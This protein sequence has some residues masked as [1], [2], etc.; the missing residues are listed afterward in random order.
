MSGDAVRLSLPPSAS[1]TPRS[2]LESLSREDLIY[3]IKKQVDN[4]KLSRLENSKLSE[5]ILSLRN[6]LKDSEASDKNVNLTEGHNFERTDLE[7]EN[8]QLKKDVDSLKDLIA[9]LEKKLE[10]NKTT[11]NTATAVQEQKDEEDVSEAR[12]ELM[13]VKNQNKELQWTVDELR[14]LLDD[15]NQELTAFKEKR[16]VENVFSLEIADYEKTVEK[17]QK[18]LKFS[19]EECKSLTN[20]LTKSRDEFAAVS[21]EKVRLNTSLNKMKAAILKMKT[22]FDEKKTANE[23]AEKEI[24]LLK[25]KISSLNE[26]RDAE[27]LSFSEAISNSQQKIHQLEENVLLLNKEVESLRSVKE[28][29]QRQYED[30]LEEHNTF[31]ARATFVLQQKQS[32]NV[33]A[34]EDR[35]ESLEETIRSQK[36]SLENLM[37]S[38]HVLQ[39]ELAAEREYSLSLASKLR[40]AEQQMNAT[41]EAHKKKFRLSEQ[42]QEFEARFVSEAQLNHE[43]ATQIDASSTQ[44]KKEK[45][46]LLLKF[47]EERKETALKMEQ[48][49]KNLEEERQKLKEIEC[50]KVDQN[51]SIQRPFHGDDINMSSHCQ[52]PAPLV[53]N[54]VSFNEVTNDR[55]LEEVLY[56]DD[57]SVNPVE[58]WEKCVQTINW[59]N[60]AKKAQKQLENT[61]EILSESEAANVRLMEQTKLLKAE[62]RR[63]ERNGE[64]TDHVANTEYLKNIIIK[65]LAPEKVDSEREQLIPVLA[66]MLK[67]NNDEIELL[68]SVVQADAPIESN[69][70]SGWGSYLHRW[71]GFS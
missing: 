15:T 42:R 14:S 4:L 17:L 13:K 9:N 35:L 60:V 8:K 38:Q 58:N 11:D 64:R 32:N 62:I 69:K 28:S 23:S 22:N 18:E 48:L 29:F 56:G 33:E 19:K 51:V 1:A 71:S 37:H 5:E 16:S 12:E 65:F 24:L 6:A 31:K 41:L 52:S 7:K 45:E 61:R 53:Q 3:F 59:E 63:M 55:T 54:P 36:K 67:L 46:E 21:D 30:L 49:K 26:E 27:K 2:K 34:D 47:D 20:D 10:E 25:E 39:D 44:H 68:N 66:T 43:L 50:S 70:M 40:E 57:L